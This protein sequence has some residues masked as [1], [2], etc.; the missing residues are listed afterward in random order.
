MNHLMMTV[1]PA[2]QLGSSSPQPPHSFQRPALRPSPFPPLAA[3][4]SLLWPPLPGCWTPGLLDT[5][6]CKA[7]E[8]EM[9]LPSRMMVAHAFNQEEEEDLGHLQCYMNS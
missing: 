6:F 5:G 7:I 2:H 4:E 8:V 3:S 9:H 1:H